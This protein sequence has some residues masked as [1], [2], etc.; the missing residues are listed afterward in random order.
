[1]RGLCLVAER[2]RAVVVID[3]SFDDAA[4]KRA[5]R[6]GTENLVD[7]LPVHGHAAGQLRQAGFAEGSR[8][9]NYRGAGA[10]VLG[11]RATAAGVG[12]C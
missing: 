10:D 4:L 7:D 11:R 5:G 9:R 8:H 3:D 6:D 12:D 2:A 1:M